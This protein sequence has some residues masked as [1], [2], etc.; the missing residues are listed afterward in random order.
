[1]G[2]RIPKSAEE[3]AGAETPQRRRESLTSSPSICPQDRTSPASIFAGKHHL[4]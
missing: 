1:M 4:E 3:D 2:Q